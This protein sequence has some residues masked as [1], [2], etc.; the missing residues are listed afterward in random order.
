MLNKTKIILPFA[1][2]ISFLQFYATKLLF[3]EYKETLFKLK[4][5]SY[6]N[7]VLFNFKKLDFE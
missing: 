4:H 3:L 7:V 6:Q 2:F 1:V 5:L